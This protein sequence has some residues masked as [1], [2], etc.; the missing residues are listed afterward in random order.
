MQNLLRALISGTTVAVLTGS[1]CEPEQ[2]PP[3]VFTTAE[4]DGGS[5]DPDDFYRDLVSRYCRYTP[6]CMGM[7]SP[8]GTQDACLRDIEDPDGADAVK[9]LRDGQ[10]CKPG[11][12]DPDEAMD[13]NIAVGRKVSDALW[14]CEASNYGTGTPLRIQSVSECSDLCLPK[15]VLD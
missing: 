10:K 7:M 5:Y 2:E 3:G 15:D 4:A 9:W 1:S 14:F 11:T 12:N 13:C 6:E 8:W